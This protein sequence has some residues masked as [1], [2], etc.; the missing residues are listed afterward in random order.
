MNLT[1]KHIS[2]LE[3]LT[4]AP[5]DKCAEAWSSTHQRE[6]DELFA[7]YYIEGWYNRSAATLALDIH[8]VAEAERLIAVALEDI[9]PKEIE[10]ELNELSEKIEQFKQRPAQKAMA[11]ARQILEEINE[12]E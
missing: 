10:I 9:P 3:R 4:R 5:I 11:E 1:P 8:N 6:I 12:S 2:L 7:V